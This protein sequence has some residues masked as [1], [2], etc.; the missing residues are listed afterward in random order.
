[1]K[2]TGWSL[3]G[4][5]GLFFLV[6]AG[7]KLA[8]PPEVVGPTLELGWPESTIVGLGVVLLISTL[9]YLWRRTAVLGAILLTGY[10]GGAVAT[11]VR[12]GGPAFSMVFPVVF[13]CLVWG[14][15]WLRDERLRR[16]LPLVSA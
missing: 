14:G 10:L 8:K 3:S 1:M 12:V 13:G 4:L 11:H 5:A 2:K 16:L 7:M 15:L 9:L 6:D